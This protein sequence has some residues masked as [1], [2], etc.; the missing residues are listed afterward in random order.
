MDE[1]GT[2]RLGAFD[3]GCIVVG[4]I[5][6]VGIF[7]T[8]ARVAQRVDDVP[9]LLT[10]WVVGGVVALLG[11]LVFAELARRV[12]GHGGTLLYVRRAFGDLPAFVYG[13][14]NTLVIQAGALGVIGLVLVD[15]LAVA[16][17][18]PEPTAG[19]KVAVAVLAILAFT[20]LNARG[21]RVGAGT[22]N[23]LTV[24]KIAA[25]GG[26]VG[27]AL[28]GA[29]GGGEAALAAPASDA[30]PKGWLVALGAAILPVMF[31]Y[32]GW[33][34]GSFVA[35]AARDPKR[36]VPRGMLGGVSVIVITYLAVNVAFLRLL[37]FEGAR[38]SSAIAA[39]AARAALAPSGHGDLAAR[40]LAG[41]VVVSCLGILNTILLA[42]PYVV[43]AMS[44]EGLLPA[45]VGRL[46]STTG[47]P[48]I[49]VLVQGLWAALLLGGVWLL[50]RDDP[51]SV[52]DVLLE[53][54]V[55]VDWIFYGACGAA[56]L[57]L[58]HR[59][60]DVPA[61][62]R[63]GGLFGVEP[64]RAVARLFVLA[65][66]AITAGALAS[67]SRVPALTGLAV[68]GLGVLAFPLLRRRVPA[69]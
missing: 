47:A 30:A 46:S 34:Q 38:A 2:R 35:G 53:G 65:S 66:F 40:L 61:T 3:I 9:Q 5:L 17:G 15:N 39:D 26:L 11:G 33:Q 29:A 50:R 59:Q 23:V 45:G 44:K 6:G 43:H 28:W 32:G 24:A 14:A 49:A 48:V 54:V 27:L 25:V 16:L 31:S 21:L 41:A 56:L 52:L 20:A 10:A 12:P 64:T 68:C 57:V 22:Q 8:P 36:D 69:Q 7:F 42:P 60:R 62:Q 1:R 18:R 4:G 55:F 13:W 63:D 58:L 19:A 37:G 51:G 67:T